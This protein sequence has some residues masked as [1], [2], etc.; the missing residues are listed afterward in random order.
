MSDLPQISIITPSYNQD[1][2]LRSTILSVLNQ[3]YPYLE[4]GIV[5]GK[6]TDS[7]VEIIREYEDHLAWWVSEPDQGQ[8]DAI[9][10]GMSKVNGEIV[11]WLNSDDIYFPG[12]LK[13][14][15]TVFETHDVGMV[16]GDAIT[17]DERG[18]P[19]NYLRIKDWGLRDL[20]RFNMICQPAV[21]MKRSVWEKLGGLD[22]SYHY[23]LDHHLWIRIGV[24]YD[25]YYINQIFAASRHHREAKNVAFAAEFSKEI[26]RLKKFIENFEGTAKLYQNDKRRING[27]AYRL[28]ARYLLDGKQPFQASVNY[29]KAL[30]SWPSDAIKYWRRMLFSIISMLTGL[31]IEH[32]NMRRTPI[33]LDMKDDLRDWPGLSISDVK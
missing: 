28:S 19:L 26:F 29:L 20:M 2:F 27:G 5:D 31:Q 33:N 11:G 8:A 9:N 10:K 32:L 23:M 22:A 13:K 4:Y 21:F 25:I 7:S 17:I 15:V 3:D 24:D 18:V 6:S 12:V 30:Y 16:Y 1:A 14:V